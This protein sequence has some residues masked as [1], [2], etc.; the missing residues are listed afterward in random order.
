MLRLRVDES[1][2]AW[3]EKIADH[4]HGGNTSAAV[5]QILKDARDDDRMKAMR[6][7]PQDVCDYCSEKVA[8]GQDGDGGG[9]LLAHPKGARK[10]VCVC[11]QD[12]CH[13]AYWQEREPAKEDK[14]GQ[15][16]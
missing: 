9:S 11:N 14:G 15:D 7:A 6:Q 2:H 4:Y 13:E 3:V 5:R 8:I 1:L 16:A 10:T 12:G